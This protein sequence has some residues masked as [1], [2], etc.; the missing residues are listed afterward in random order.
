MCVNSFNHH[1][2]V[3]CTLGGMLD[4]IPTSQMEKKKKRKLGQFKVTCPMSVRMS[5]AEVEF[6]PRQCGSRVQAFTYSPPTSP[7]CEPDSC[8]GFSSVSCCGAGRESMDL[9]Q[10]TVGAAGRAAGRSESAPMHAHCP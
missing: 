3:R 7:D 5:I 9:E 2:N 6:Q 4:F 1:N 8:S 10:R